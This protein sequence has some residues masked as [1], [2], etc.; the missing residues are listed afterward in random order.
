MRPE[1]LTPEEFAARQE[2]SQRLADKHRKAM[3]ESLAIFED[4]ITGKRPPTKARNP[5]LEWA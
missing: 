2:A 4:E 3:A 5:L 1:K